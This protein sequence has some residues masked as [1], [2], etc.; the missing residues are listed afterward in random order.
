MAGE[1]Q[2]TAEAA[3]DA[4]P[5]VVVAEQAEAPAQGHRGFHIPRIVDYLIVAIFMYF[6][7]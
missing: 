7:L 6:T 1:E 4:I 2:E 5:L 3:L